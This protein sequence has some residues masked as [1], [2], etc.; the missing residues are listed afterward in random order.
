MEDYL[1]T[2]VTV[3][4]DRF[5]HF[6][7]SCATRSL[8]SLSASVNMNN[9]TAITDRRLTQ[10]HSLRIPLQLRI[11]GTNDPKRCAESVDFSGRGALLETELPL[12]VGSA[13]ELHLK[14]PEALTGQPTTEWRCM[15]RVVRVV[16]CL[17]STSQLRV[18][19]H[20]DSLDVSRL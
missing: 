11:W 19:V 14:L 9:S 12:Q 20:F 18:G 4:K 8:L 10:R 5:C 6:I 1:T 3:S 2:N 7:Y 15:G 16:Q 13:V 17:P